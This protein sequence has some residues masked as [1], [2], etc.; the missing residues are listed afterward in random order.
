MDSSNG[1]WP[2]GIKTARGN[3]PMRQGRYTGL[4]RGRQAWRCGRWRRGGP[5]AQCQLVEQLAQAAAFFIGQDRHSGLLVR[6]GLGGDGQWCQPT[7]MQ[8]A[9][10]LPP[11]GRQ[12][13]RQHQ[14]PCTG[15]GMGLGEA[16]KGV[17]SQQL[18]G[19]TMDQ[20]ARRAKVWRNL[21]TL[22]AATARQ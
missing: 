5:S 22:G 7:R 20:R 21:A 6:I 4:Q 11:S 12:Q 3:K 9:V 17:H 18:M 16:A 15:L 13:D 8:H 10:R 2:S 1:G 19:Q 14:Q